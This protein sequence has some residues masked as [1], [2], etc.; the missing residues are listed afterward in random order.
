MKIGLIRHFKV[1]RGYPD[2]WVTSKELMNWAVEY[3]ESDVIEKKI[4]LGNIQWKHCFSSDLARAQRT[5]ENTF[6]GNIVFLEELREIRISPIFS[7]NRKLPLF[8]HMLLIRAAWFFN[9]KSQPD[10]KKQVTER[11]NQALDK[12]MGLQE[13]VLIISHGGI[14]MFLSRELKK[15]GFTGPALN[16]PQNARLYLYEKNML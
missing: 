2:K 6:S 16:R 9:H 7:M 8:I 5:A 1:K 13:D 15:R 4:D 11:L 3:D 12:M 10:G 14:M